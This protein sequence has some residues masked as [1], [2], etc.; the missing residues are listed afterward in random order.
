PGL[1]PDSARAIA[2]LRER[3]LGEIVVR[4]ALRRVPAVKG[5]ANHAAVVTLL[6]DALNANPDDGEAHRVLGDALLAL[7]RLDEAGSHYAKALSLDGDDALAHR[8]LGFAL[9]RAGRVREAIPHYEA[10]ITLGD[11]D[12]EIHN[13]LG[14]AL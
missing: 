12:P 5:E 14:A 11:D 1:D 2:A 7:G 9:H 10:A 6:S 4:S 8:G 3:N 13:N